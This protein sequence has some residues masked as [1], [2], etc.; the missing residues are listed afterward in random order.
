MSASNSF[1]RLKLSF[2]GGA[3]EVGRSCFFISYIL[4]NI[5]LDAG[6]IKNIKRFNSLPSFS[7]KIDKNKKYLVLISHF[8]FDHTGSLPVLINYTPGNYRVIS[9]MPTKLLYYKNFKD[10]LLLFSNNLVIL[11]DLE[12]SMELFENIHDHENIQNLYL[13]IYFINSG[14][15][16]GSSMIEIENNNMKLIYTGDYNNS[17]SFFYSN[18]IFKIQKIDFLL[19]EC[20]MNSLNFM[21]KKI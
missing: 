12:I 8:H 6:A 21:Q 11:E 10:F 16:F 13:K 1:S 9:K 18:H 4:I 2:L 5:I 14:H 20:T 15:V 17:E 3:R 7:P 19:I